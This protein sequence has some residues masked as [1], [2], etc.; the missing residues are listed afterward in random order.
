M[1]RHNTTKPTN[2]TT[3]RFHFPHVS[4]AHT[5]HQHSSTIQQ[6]MAKY[7]H[8]VVEQEMRIK[9][10]TPTHYQCVEEVYIGSES[11]CNEIMAENQC[12][13]AAAASGN[14]MTK[15]PQLEWDPGKKNHSQYSRRQ[16]ARIQTKPV[17]KYNNRNRNGSMSFIRTANNGNKLPSPVLFF[18]LPA[19]L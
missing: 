5:A 15:E 8:S 9:S 13:H 16:T 4:S 7:I 11:N 12:R 18:S 1:S 10:S 2:K 6:R 19:S 17:T 3:R 14:T